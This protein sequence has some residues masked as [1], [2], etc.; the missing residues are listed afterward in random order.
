MPAAPLNYFAAVGAFLGGWPDDYL[1]V[2]VETQGLDPRAAT[3]LPL[4]LGYCVVEGREVAAA[5]SVVLDWT[6]HPGVECGPLASSIAR[7]RHGMAARGQAYRF[8]LSVLQAEGVDPLDGL[9]SYRRLLADTLAGG[10]RLVGHNFHAYDR[11]LLEAAFFRHLGEP[12]EIPASSIF[13]TGMVE[14]ARV[15]KTCPPASGL[16]IDDWYTRTSRRRGRGRWNLGEHCDEVYGLSVDR[17]A[18]HD[19]ANDCITTMRLMEA[20]RALTSAV[21]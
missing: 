9:R 7:C 19:A 3:T 14:K 18:S 5:G 20:M 2:D 16:S 4:Q 15:M 1:V 11:P 12:L 10:G 6:R 21:P 13:D 17:S 8:S